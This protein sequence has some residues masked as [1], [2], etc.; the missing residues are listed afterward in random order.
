MMGQKESAVPT[1]SSPTDK[2][3]L[4]PPEDALQIAEGGG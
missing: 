3:H 1:A 2:A 4:S